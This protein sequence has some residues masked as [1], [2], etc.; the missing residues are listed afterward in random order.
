MRIAHCLPPSSVLGRVFRRPLSVGALLFASTAASASGNGPFGLPDMPIVDGQVLA[1]A[2]DGDLL[3]VGGIF[4]MVG[5][6]TGP[7]VE[8]DLVSGAISLQS[9]GIAAAEENDVRTVV[10]DGSG[11]WYIGGRFTEVGG[12]PRRGLARVLADGSVD[13]AF[14]AQLDDD[15]E[16]LL[17]HAGNLYVM[18][19]FSQ[20]GASARST[21]AAVDPTTGA[22]TMWAPEPNRGIAAIAV[23]PTGLLVGGRFD[24]I[25]GVQ[26]SRFAELDPISG[27][28]T[29][30][31]VDINGGSNRLVTALAVVGNTAYLGGSFTGI[32]GQPRDRLAAVDLSTG[33]PTAWNPGADANPNVLLAADDVLWVGGV[34]SMLDGT[35]RQ[36]VGAFDLTSGNLS[37]W[38]PALGADGYVEAIALGGKGTVILGGEFDS[39][40]GVDRLNLVEVDDS[41]GMAV[42]FGQGTG[43]PVRALARDGARLMVGG[44]FAT[45]GGL[46]RRNLAAYTVSTGEPTAWAPSVSAQN[47]LI[48]DVAVSG[49]TLYVGGGFSEIN[50]AAR[51]NLAAINA[52]DGTLLPWNPAPN[53]FV[54]ALEIVDDSV[55]VGGEFGQIGGQSRSFL[56]E[57]DATSGAASAWAPSLSETVY[58]LAVSDDTA[59]VGLR[60]GDS[61]RANSAF[62]FDLVSAMPTAWDPNLINQ[63][64]D[65]L[66]IDGAEVLVGG[67]FAQLGGQ[68]RENLGAVDA[69]VGLAT[70][71]DPGAGGRVG[72]LL[73]DGRT[74]YVAGS[75]NGAGT[76]VA[77]RGG[78]GSVGVAAVDRISGATVWL[79]EISGNGSAVAL[80]GEW[81]A[82]GGNFRSMGRGGLLLLRGPEFLFADGFE[83]P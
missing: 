56:A 73:V 64:V 37:T 50:G 10:S 78:Q 14:D 4:D 55:Y 32:G 28:A 19:D 53:D 34:F 30:L 2:A 62:A 68:P 58:A 6:A 27:A 39:V 15:V 16:L 1:M 74:V 22:V 40:G 26:R 3:Y 21:A 49:N 5:P 59:Y 18:G 25:G 75:I 42:G 41:S 54:Y 76:G 8:I 35:A 38:D 70:G 33:L 9:L 31:Q 52:D 44:D 81:V 80:S 17:L 36:G 13:P 71:W 77:A 29:A 24:N 69:T 46:I 47:P 72:D 43:Q 45:V 83:A 65:S 66:A 67:L 63:S 79:P 57:L 82:V 7:A 23:G 51:E 60:L 12:L 61:I 11:G 20:V 48:L